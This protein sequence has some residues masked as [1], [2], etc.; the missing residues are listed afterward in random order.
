MEAVDQQCASR[1]F[2]GECK[3]ISDLIAGCQRRRVDGGML[4]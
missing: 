3:S 4:P 2:T 1:V